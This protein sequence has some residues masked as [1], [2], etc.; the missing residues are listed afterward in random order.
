MSYYVQGLTQRAGDIAGTLSATTS[1]GCQ[2]FSDFVGLT[3][4][5]PAF[6]FSQE[7]QGIKVAGTG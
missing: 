6:F 1:C 2:V 5:H 7:N 4:A 3:D